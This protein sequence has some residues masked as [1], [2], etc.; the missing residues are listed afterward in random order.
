MFEDQLFQY[1]KATQSK[2]ITER[3][4]QYA[5]LKYVC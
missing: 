4:F 2:I 1:D 5:T 3:K